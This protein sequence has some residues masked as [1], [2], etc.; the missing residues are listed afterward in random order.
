MMKRFIYLTRFFFSDGIAYG[1]PAT[2]KAWTIDV[3]RAYIKFMWIS[4]HDRLI[5]GIDYD[6]NGVGGS[7]INKDALMAR[8]CFYP[9]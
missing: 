9:K 6:T 2:I 8:P 5:E 3:P 7:C 1:N 4:R